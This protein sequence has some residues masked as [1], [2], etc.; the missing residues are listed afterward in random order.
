MK[1][2]LHYGRG[3]G[4]GGHWKFR[5]TSGLSLLLGD[6]DAFLRLPPPE[7]KIGLRR[8]NPGSTFR[9]YRA[10]HRIVTA[11]HGIVTAPHGIV[12]FDFQPAYFSDIMSANTTLIA[13][14]MHSNSSTASEDE[15]DVTAPRIEGCGLG[16]ACAV[17]ICRPNSH[18]FEE[19]TVRLDQP[20]KIG[21]SVARCRPSHDNAIFDCK[22]LSRNHALLWYE[23]GKF[24]LQDTKSSNGTFVNNQ[25]LSKGSEES[26]P[27]EIYSGDIVQFGV[28]VVENSKKVTHGCIVATMKL[29]LPDGKEAK[30]SPSTSVMPS[31]AGS[32]STNELYELHQYIQEATHREQQME[33]KL[34]ALQ[35]LI[36]AIQEAG[37][38][39]W[40]SL[41]DE[42]RLLTRV[43]ILESQLYLHSKGQTEDKLKERLMEL[44]E[45][46]NLYQSTAKDSIRKNLQEKLDAILKLSVSERA[47]QS[48]ED[49]CNHLRTMND[50][51]KEEMSKILEKHEEQVN[52]TK[53]L[54]TKLQELEKEIEEKQKALDE[55]V[56]KMQNHEN[57]LKHNHENSS[58]SEGAHGIQVDLLLEKIEESMDTDLKSALRHSRNEVVDLKQKL[59]NAESDTKE[60]SNRLVDLSSQLETAR[61]EANRYLNQL[62]ILEVELEETK[63]RKSLAETL[64]KELEGSLEKMEKEK[65]FLKEQ[66]EKA[67]SKES[68]IGDNVHVGSQEFD[69][70]EEKS[71]LVKEVSE[72]RGLVSILASSDLLHKLLEESRGKRKHLEDMV[73]SSKSRIDSLQS[74]LKETELLVM[75]FQ[76]QLEVGERV[77]REKEVRI[78]ELSAEVLGCQKSMKESQSRIHEL[79]D[80]L[81]L[82]IQSREKKEQI[83]NQTSQRLKDVQRELD[84]KENM[85]KELRAKLKGALNPEPQ[86][87]PCDRS[88]QVNLHENSSTEMLVPHANAS[89]VDQESEAERLQ[90]ELESMKE[91]VV[92]LKQRYAECNEERATFKV[93]RDRFETDY[94]EIA[95]HTDVITL[96][97]GIPIVILLV[98]LICALHPFFSAITATFES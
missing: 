23:K 72:L 61:N 75:K 31:L 30:A 95:R 56:E 25:R 80:L 21:R 3:G 41:I 9:R 14:P 12:T 17:L 1:I 47:L 96:C 88:S 24:F 7:G 33:N 76:S 4:G 98:S 2:L 55:E 29:V 22:V 83:L 8:N 89:L 79:Q 74:S 87:K 93:E 28:D 20:V 10:P 60:N 84:A 35:K 58:I 86:S 53:E 48:T 15:D 34:Q 19:R 16:V 45:E 59:I 32:V 91:E 43:E 68:V 50:Q 13:S 57:E 52:K 78:E 66:L 39:G 71:S 73:D 82:E 63:T 46:K 36:A 92:H 40:K 27:R 6:S 85:L 38:K 70:N 49:E 37:E 62:K 77:V 97:T 11:P 94:K 67:Q 81:Q 5:R 54:T 69:G 26:H 42:D 18:P 90:A 64:V 44:E 51:M 65:V